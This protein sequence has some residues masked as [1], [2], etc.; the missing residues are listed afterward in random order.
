[1]AGT[2]TV[3]LRTLTGWEILGRDR[4]AGIY[5]EGLTLSANSWGSDTC[6]FTLRRDPGVQHSDL[7]AFTPCEVEVNGV[8]VWSGRVFETPT[9][10]GV[11]PNISV[12]GRGWQYHLDDDAYTK[13][14]VHARLNDWVDT[15]SLSTADLTLMTTGYQVDAGNRSILLSLP[16][17]ATAPIGTYV[18]AVLDLGP[19][20]TAARIVLTADGGGKVNGRLLLGSYN[21]SPT[22]RGAAVENPQ[23][24][25]NSPTTSAVFSNTFSTAR[26]WIELELYNGTGV[27]VTGDETMRIRITSAQLFGSTAWESG[28][29][30]ILKATDVIKDALPRAPLLSQSTAGISTTAF[31]IPEFYFFDFRTPREVISA[32]NAYHNYRT[33]VEVDTTLSFG[34]Y[35][36]VP[37]YEIGAQEMVEFQD[38]SANSGEGIYN[39]VIVQ[40]TGPD[41]TSLVA[42]RTSSPATTL[43]DLRGFSRTMILPVQSALTTAAANQIGDVYLANHRTTAFKGSMTVAPRGL[44]GL[45]SYGD[46]HPSELLIGAGELVRFPGRIDPDTGALGREG[47]IASVTY[48]NDT[49]TSTVEIDSERRNFEALLARLA[50]FTPAG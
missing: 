33:R 11:D 28:N 29:A 7:F 49:E 20:N 39:K 9:S 16:S 14:F 23:L 26:Q 3:R 41:G 34:P 50:V 38:V 12:Q 44:R 13:M 46:V 30:S 48:N 43:P 2:A 10:D 42:T 25:A 47:R 35:P 8:N 32:V 6:G 45:G 40:G 5:P 27:V 1:M 18:G 31:S 22:S 21:A 19:G 15:R 17:A 37:L 4:L 24:S 36:T